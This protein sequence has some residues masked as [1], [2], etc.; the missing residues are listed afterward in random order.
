[1]VCFADRRSVFNLLRCCRCSDLFEQLDLNSDFIVD[2]ETGAFFDLPVDPKEKSLNMLNGIYY[3]SDLSSDNSTYLNNI[4]LIPGREYE[5]K[6]D[7]TLICG[8]K[9]FRIEII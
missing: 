6:S 2:I 5:I 1:M 3:I 7:Q 8:N 4:R 9:E